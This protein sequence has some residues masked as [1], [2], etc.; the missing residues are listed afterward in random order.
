MATTIKGH[1]TGVWGVYLAVAQLPNT[2]GATEQSPFV[3]KGH[4]GITIISGTPAVYIC[5]TPTEGAGVWAQ[6]MHTGSSV[7]GGLT[8][9]G[10]LSAEQVTSTDDATVTDDLAITGLLTVGETLGVTGA[11]TLAAVACTTLDPSG[12]LAAAAAVTVGTTLGVTGATTTTGG[13]AQAVAMPGV[14]N[15]QITGATNGTDKT[16]ADGTQWVTSVFVPANFTCTNIEFLVGSVGGTDRVYGVIYDAAGTVLKNSDLTS[17]GI[18]CGT[19][20]QIMQL[21]L[22]A[23]QALTGPATYYVGISAKG[24]TCRI[25]TLPVYLGGSCFAGDVAQTHAT[26]AAIT[27]PPSFTA[28]EGPYIIL[29]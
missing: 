7:T 5:T 15:I 20:A 6:V 13:I 10:T 17:D 14:H 23:T 8:L 11:S 1:H 22:T 2:S 12:L 26:V 28:D 21:P 25:R 3:R 24:T 18:V 27:P 19:A 4:I 16:P 9:S 29:T